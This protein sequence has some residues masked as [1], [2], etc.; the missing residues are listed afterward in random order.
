MDKIFQL[1]PRLEGQSSWEQW[2]FRIRLALEHHEDALEVVEGRLIEP[3]DES[4]NTNAT[5][6]RTYETTLRRFQKADA[7]AKLILTSSMTDETMLKMMR[8]KTARTMWEELVLLYDG[9]PQNKAYNVCIQFFHY[10]RLSGEDMPSHL[11]KV[12][13]LWNELTSVA[14]KENEVVLPDFLL[15]CKILDTLSERYLPFKSSWLMVN[16]ELRTIENLTSQ[17]C[18]FELNLKTSV[19]NQEF[20]LVKAKEEKQSKVVGNEKKKSK[21]LTCF[22]V[23]SQVI[24]LETVDSGKQMENRE[25]SFQK[26]TQKKRVP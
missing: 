11:S 19:D 1:I 2:R 23:K 22:Y 21:V 20:C 24:F 25:R 7:L 17:L 18:A 14:A 9:V 10:Q 8:F 12:K 13:T 16:K 15:I 3:P 4:E 6:R 26:V 5:V